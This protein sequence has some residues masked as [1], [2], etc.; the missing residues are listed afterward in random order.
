L[1]KEPDFN[2]KHYCL[3]I[4]HLRVNPNILRAAPAYLY[5]S[6][7]PFSTALR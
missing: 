7:L 4:R 3:E 2:L 5:W 6:E 1:A